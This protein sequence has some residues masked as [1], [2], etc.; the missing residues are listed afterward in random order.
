M[1]NEE[2]RREKGEGMREKGRR[3]RYDFTDSDVFCGLIKNAL[4]N[5][6]FWS[7]EFISGHIKGPKTRHYL[8]KSRKNQVSWPTKWAF[9]RQPRNPSEL[10]ILNVA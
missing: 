3:K 4:R 10:A 6:V 7:R 5:L 1:A 8:R 2:G 9:W